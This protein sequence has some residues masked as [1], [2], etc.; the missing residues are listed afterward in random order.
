MM[1]NMDTV[2]VWHIT[3]RN[4]TSMAWYKMGSDGYEIEGC[5]R[6]D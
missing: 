4:S 5:L 6:Y 2:V 1:V 3:V